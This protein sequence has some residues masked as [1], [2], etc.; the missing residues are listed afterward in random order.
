MTS[1]RN[2]IAQVSSRPLT[3]C[4][5]A[6]GR[7]RMKRGVSRRPRTRP[8]AD[9]PRGGDDLVGV[10]VGSLAHLQRGGRGQR[11]GAGGL[12]V[13]GGL[14]LHAAP[15]PTAWPPW[16]PSRSCD[17]PARA[18]P[19][20]CRPSAASS[21]RVRER[22][23]VRRPFGRTPSRRAASRGG[24][25]SAGGRCRRS[26]ARMVAI[27]AGSVWCGGGWSGGW[28]GRPTASAHMSAGT[29]EDSGDP[30]AAGVVGEV[31]V[32]QATQQRDP[33]QEVGLGDVAEAGHRAVPALEH[34]QRRCVGLGRSAR[35][36]GSPAR[37]SAGSGGGRRWRSRRSGRA[38]WW[39]AVRGSGER[40]ASSSS[41]VDLVVA[42]R[43]RRTWRRRS[44][45]SSRSGC[46]ATVPACRSGTATSRS[47][48]WVSPVS[49][50]MSHAASRISRRTAR[51]AFGFPITSRCS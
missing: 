48:I 36:R 8:G 31:L 28:G 2:P 22:R 49:R 4:G 6:K 11:V 40:A 27:M 47:V 7:L 10:P 19:T 29:F 26:T 33:D 13:R 9:A 17:R 5:S 46:R 1:L 45:S 30:G 41:R 25:G 20:R 15:S 43:L 51:T 44:P 42:P 37:S 21:R 35:S 32:D 18:R 39:S 50:A 12:G 23:D 24:A 34:A 38:T 3:C 16:R 14:A